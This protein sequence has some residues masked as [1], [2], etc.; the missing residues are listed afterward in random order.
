M[1]Q[2]AQ[3]T[4]ASFW[5]PHLTTPVAWQQWAADPASSAEIN[6][7]KAD[8]ISVPPLLRRRLSPLGRAVAQ[9]TG[10][11]ADALTSA[12]TALVFASR[13]GDVHTAVKE[14]RSLVTTDQLSPTLFATSVHNGIGAIL[15]I[16]HRHH[17]FETA[18]AAGPFSL[19]AGFMSAVGLLTEYPRVLLC[20]YDAVS[21]S[22]FAEK[23][24]FTHACAFL[25]EAQRET[26]DRDA[27][28]EAWNRGP[29]LAL[30]SSPRTEPLPDTHREN[31]SGMADLDV[32]RWL[33]HDDSPFLTRH[34]RHAE[35]TW[36]KNAR[37]TLPD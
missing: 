20:A 14:L 35:W 22:E 10:C 3:L 29:F 26:E 31:L 13:W 9:A 24:T 5:A 15:S 8:A 37:L 28:F 25:L 34:D 21:P 12:E 11:F 36:A 33:L 30:A 23:D 19:E 18:V 16:A 1:N 17:G 32:V 2:C 4:A 6:E 7:T 27:F